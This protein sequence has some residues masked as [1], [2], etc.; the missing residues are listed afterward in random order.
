M[1]VCAEFEDQVTALNAHKSLIDKG[2]DPDDIEVR[3]PYPLAEEPIPPHWSRPMIM[4]NVVRFMWLCGLLAG[5]SFLCFTQ[6]EWGEVARTDGQPLVAIP[7]NAVIM[8]ECGMFTAIWVTTFMFFIE[9][10]RHRKLVPALEEDMPVA[11]G[12]IALVVRGESARKAADWLKGHGARS[13]V[14]FALPLVML[15]FLSTGCADHN[16]RYQDVVKPTEQSAAPS[17]PQ[18]LSMPTAAQMSPPPPEPFGY[19]TAG[20]PMAY[21]RL[22]A[23]VKAK[24]AEIEA[25]G[26]KGAEARKQ[27]AAFEE[28]I[29]AQLAEVTPEIEELKSGAVPP[30]LQNLENPVPSTPESIARGQVLYQVNCASCHGATGKGDGPVGQLTYIPPPDIG[31]AR[32][33]TALTDGGFYYFIMVGKNLMPAFAY[34]MNTHEIFDLVNYLRA[35]Q[36][37]G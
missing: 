2:A 20:N 22:T 33:Q 14:S 3:S 36:A 13:I 15:A 21:D 26:V 37:K 19:L 5:F 10:R 9:T 6:L 31:S 32:Y 28:S 23:D 1:R 35:L 27:I 29:A 12:H 18:S 34:K 7:I 8:Y 16:M 17:P 30:E 24:K 25:A 11:M 4:R